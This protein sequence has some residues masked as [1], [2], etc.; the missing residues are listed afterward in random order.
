MIKNGAFDW[1]WGFDFLILTRLSAPVTCGLPCGMRLSDDWSYGYWKQSVGMEKGL[2]ILKGLF[3]YQPKMFLW[4]LRQDSSPSIHIYHLFILGS[5]SVLWMYVTIVTWCW[6]SSDV[7]LADEDT[8]AI[9]TDHGNR[10]GQYHVM[11]RQKVAK[12]VSGTNRCPH[13][14]PIQEKAKF[15]TKARGAT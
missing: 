11:R 7:T 10:T 8:N 13:L 6:D 3:L 9:P 1:F 15:T 4:K 5:E 2:T 12:F 14:H